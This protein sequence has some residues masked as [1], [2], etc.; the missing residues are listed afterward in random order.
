MRLAGMI[1]DRA[2]SSGCPQHCSMRPCHL[3]VIVPLLAADPNPNLIQLVHAARVR[4]LI[5]TCTTLARYVFYF[6]LR[7]TSN[8]NLVKVLTSLTLLC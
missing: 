2:G 3:L 5:T 6:C 4:V 1:C 7:L 8:P